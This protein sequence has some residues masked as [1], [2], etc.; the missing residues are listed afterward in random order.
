MLEA[1]V[2]RARVEQL[3]LERGLELDR[4]RHPVGVHVGEVI[5][6]GALVG[7]LL[8]DL[9]VARPGGTNFED[10]AD[11]SSAFLSNFDRQAI[12]VGFTL[13]LP[14]YGRYTDGGP[15]RSR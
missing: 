12:R 11:L 9:G 3:L 4:G 5:V 2:L 7:G 13:W 15:A 1:L 6:V 14:L 10:V 8:D